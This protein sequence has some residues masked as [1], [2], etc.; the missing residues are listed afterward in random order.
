MAASVSTRQIEWTRGL[1]AELGF[2]EEP[3]PTPGS[4][5]LSAE[6]IL[7]KEE[8]ET[9]WLLLIDN[10][11]T[12]ANLNSGKIPKDNHQNA[13]LFAYVKNATGNLKQVKP[14]KVNTLY[15]TADI[16]TKLLVFPVHDGHC[17]SITSTLTFI[18]TGTEPVTK[19]SQSNK[20]QKV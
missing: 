8:I 1:F 15:N 2:T 16:L 20:R 5:P 18:S 11:A 12:V 17:R 13:R 9:P 14:W 6:E 4:K 3:Q 19:M 10:S 7:D